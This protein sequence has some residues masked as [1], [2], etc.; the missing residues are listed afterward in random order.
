V[1]VVARVDRGEPGRMN[2]AAQDDDRDR[3]RR[4]VL[5]SEQRI[6]EFVGAIGVVLRAP[7]IA[8]IVADV[9]D[10]LVEARIDSFPPGREARQ[11]LE[12][13][14]HIFPALG[15]EPLHD[16]RAVR[17]DHRT[18]D[19]QGVHVRLVRVHPGLEPVELRIAHDAFFQQVPVGPQIQQRKADFSHPEA[20]VERIVAQQGRV[21]ARLHDRESRGR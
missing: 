13:G 5:Q 8:D 21:A 14:Q 10:R 11:Q 16:R 3:V 15:R 6:E 4:I 2:I 12:E 1:P 19:E 7:G 17:E 18:D 9:P 20:A